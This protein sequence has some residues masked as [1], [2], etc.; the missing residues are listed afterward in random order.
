MTTLIIIA[1]VLAMLGVAAALICGFVVMGKSDGGV[2]F[3]K[4]S[5]KMMQWRLYLQGLAL[6]LFALVL[7]L[8]KQ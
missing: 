6:V 4:K 3:A 5:N 8:A 7:F 2:A 1:M